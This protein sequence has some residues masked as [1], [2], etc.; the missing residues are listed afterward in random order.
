MIAVLVL[1]RKEI[2]KVESLIVSKFG[3]K[4]RNCSWE[5]WWSGHL[6]WCRDMHIPVRIP[7]PNHYLSRMFQPDSSPSACWC[8]EMPLIIP[9]GG[10]LMFKKWEE[11]SRWGKVTSCTRMASMTCFLT[12][13]MQCGLILWVFMFSKQL[14]SLC[15]FPHVQS[16]HG[17]IRG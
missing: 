2:S 7:K 14:I 1:R 6:V 12:E 5:S 16:P 15:L 4:I 3:R 13:T 10:K 9:P 11:E 17:V 8:L